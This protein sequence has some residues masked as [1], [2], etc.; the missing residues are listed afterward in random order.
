MFLF[1]ILAQTI[2]KVI[3]SK[4]MHN[5][6]L[7]L[8]MMLLPENTLAT[9]YAWCIPS[10]MRK[11]TVLLSEDFTNEINCLDI[12]LTTIIQCI[13][14]NFSRYK[15]KRLSS[16]VVANQELWERYGQGQRESASL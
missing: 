10:W 12:L 2:M 8:V 11:K 9:E 1:I 7:T 3:D 5:P 4:R 14:F 16:G 15:F 13:L 6:H